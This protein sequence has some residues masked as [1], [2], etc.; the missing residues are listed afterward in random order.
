MNL[1]Q[2]VS[3]AIGTVNPFVP[4]T[5]RLSVGYSVAP[6]GT[7]V[8]QYSTFAAVPCQVQELTQRDLRQLDGLNVQGSTKSVYLNG[9]WRGVV[10]VGAR[11]GDLLTTPDN[12][13]YLV[14]AVL[15]MWPDWSKLAVTLQN[16]S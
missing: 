3:G 7:Q 9:Q 10:R 6:D 1:H 5:L 14:T 16:G 8:P 15:E 13:T 2:I 12:L 11:G 4:C